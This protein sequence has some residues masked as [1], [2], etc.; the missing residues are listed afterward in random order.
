[1]PA[2]LHTPSPPSL[3]IVL[4][5]LAAWGSR[6]SLVLKPSPP[7]TCAIFLTVRTVEV[8]PPLRGASF[9]IPNTTS[10]PFFSTETQCQN[11]VR[12]GKAYVC[13]QCGKLIS[14]R[15]PANFTSNR[16]ACAHRN[17]RSASVYWCSFRFAPSAARTSMGRSYCRA[18]V[19]FS[20]FSSSGPKN[21]RTSHDKNLIYTTGFSEC[22]FGKF[23]K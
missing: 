6:N 22:F 23:V 17:F 15:L 19:T 11:C 5:I 7:F 1:M 14:H 9:S 21:W 12:S 18:N 10:S 8:G 2:A 20:S 4:R 13:G 3:C 16:G